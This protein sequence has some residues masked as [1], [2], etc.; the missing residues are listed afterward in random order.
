MTRR[1]R[2]LNSFCLFTACVLRRFVL[3]VTQKRQGR[4]DRAMREGTCEFAGGVEKFCATHFRRSLEVF[5]SRME[6]GCGGC[7]VVW[8]LLRVCACS[9]A[10][11][12]PVRVCVPL[13]LELSVELSRIDRISSLHTTERA[14]VDGKRSC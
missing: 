4:M 14:V 6:P 12:G 9:R 13:P 11:R 5:G 1:D 3:P 2:E 7:G 10:C 8:W